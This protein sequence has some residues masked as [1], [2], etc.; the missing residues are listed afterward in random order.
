MTVDY[1]ITA[2]GIVVAL[3]GYLM[4]PTDIGWFLLGVGSASIILGILDLVFRHPGE[5]V[6][7]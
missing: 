2:I 4:R 6:N 3:I 1:I 7:H 5:K